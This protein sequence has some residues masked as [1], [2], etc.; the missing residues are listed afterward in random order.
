M[1]SWALLNHEHHGW[2]H[3][4]HD[5]LTR[6]DQHRTVKFGLLPRSPR[7]LLEAFGRRRMRGKGMGRVSEIASVE[8]KGGGCVIPTTTPLPPRLP[9]P[10]KKNDNDLVFSV[11]SLV[12]SGFSP[13]N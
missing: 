13:L 11:T 3:I 8:Q 4:T 10:F 12:D 6:L 5:V 9:R 7:F 1:L 2:E